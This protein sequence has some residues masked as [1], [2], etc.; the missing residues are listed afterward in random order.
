MRKLK[1]LKE[2][3]LSKKKGNGE[4]YCPECRTKCKYILEEFS[5]YK[6][7]LF[8]PIY[9][10]DSNGNHVLC[11]SC[12]N[13]FWGSVLECSPEI[14]KQNFN[15]SI[16]HLMVLMMVADGK[17]EEEELQ[18]IKQIYSDLTSET[19]KDKEIQTLIENVSE[20]NVSV[21]EYLKRITP[22]LNDYK[23]TLIIKA[24]YLVSAADDIIHEKEKKLLEEIRKALKLDNDFFNKVVDTLQIKETDEST[25]ELAT[26]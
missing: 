25:Q 19:V 6:V 3:W 8:L 26:H 14:S 11:C 2:K 4:F 5:H 18:S 22:Y 7:L 23:K 21:E 15:P 16:L 17:I 9:K 20:E 13:T 24:A 10:I 1:L 12:K